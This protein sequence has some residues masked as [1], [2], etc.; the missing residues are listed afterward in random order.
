M[1][2]NIVLFLI[3]FLFAYFYLLLRKKLIFGNRDHEFE[4][5]HEEAYERV[6]R[7]EKKVGIM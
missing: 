3:T 7:K 2:F 1:H 4:R 6:C 5:D